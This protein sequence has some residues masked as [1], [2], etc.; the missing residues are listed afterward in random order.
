MEKVSVGENV[1]AVLQKKL[2]PKCKDLYGYTMKLHI[3]LYINSML[4]H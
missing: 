3:V 1:F 4:F 2:P